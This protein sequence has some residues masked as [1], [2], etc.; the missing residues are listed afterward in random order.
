MAQPALFVV[1]YALAELW[2]S[3]GIRP[4]A[5]IG[6]SVG[7][8]VAA[9]LSGV[10]SLDDALRLIA[11][12][13]R[14]ISELPAGSMLSVMADPASLA[15]YLDD[16]VCLA[17]VNAPQLCV[18]SG[19]HD[20]INRVEIELQSRSIAAH[21]L[22][23]SHAFHSSMMDP[24]LDCFAALIDRITLSPP[25]IPYVAT[26]TGHWADGEVTHCEYWTP[27]I[28]STV[29]FADALAELRTGQDAPVLLEVGPGGRC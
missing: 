5:M 11:E 25:T 21:R 27:Q 10:L 2:L 16:Y 15:A 8:Y 7:E 29:R 24:M 23:T 4:T 22:H 28:R 12:R 14:L 26:L 1:G 20:A 18:L 13:G 19:P 9:T 6:H 3:W 17:A